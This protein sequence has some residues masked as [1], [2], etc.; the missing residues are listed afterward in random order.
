MDRV[1]KQIRVEHAY[2]LGLSGKGIHICVLDTGIF[3]HTDFDRR[4]LEYIDFTKERKNFMHDFSGHGTH[5]SGIMS[6]SGRASHGRYQGI[7]CQSEL[8]MLNILNRD[9]NGNLEE[10]LQAFEWILAHYKEY[11]IRIINISIGIPKDSSL[12]SEKNKRNIVEWYLKKLHDCDILIVT[13][14]GNEGRV[15]VLGESNNTLCIGCHDGDYRSK[16]GIMCSDYS[17]CGD[18]KSCFIKPDLVAPGTE[19]ISCG[20]RHARDYTSKSGTSM[21][22]PIVSGVAALLMELNPYQ[23]VNDIMHKLRYG[24]RDLQLPFYK[25]G[26]GMLDCKRIFEEYG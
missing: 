21:S 2:R 10:M 11:K 6:G 5:V 23:S 12:L 20:N 14:A 4:I 7:A 25:Q 17:G 9:G 26:Y 1:R 22:C 13:A 15:S 8:I 18:K 24:T 3:P 16:G 19:I